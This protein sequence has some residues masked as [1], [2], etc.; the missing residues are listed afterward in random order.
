M[1]LLHPKAAFLVLHQKDTRLELEPTP[2]L[3]NPSCI[4]AAYIMRTADGK[5]IETVLLLNGSCVTV[6]E[7]V[8]EIIEMCKE[9]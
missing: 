4:S 9:T 3:V 1:S 6:V 7:S 2:I 8:D 5:P